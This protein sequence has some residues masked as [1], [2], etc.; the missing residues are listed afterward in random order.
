MLR[1]YPAALKACDQILDMLPDDSNTLASKAHVYQAQGN[2]AA[3]A[4]FASAS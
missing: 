3:A 4:A 1:Q 2:L